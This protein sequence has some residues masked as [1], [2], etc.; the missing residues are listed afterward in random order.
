MCLWVDLSGFARMR[1]WAQT[2]RARVAGGPSSWAQAKRQSLDTRRM[3]RASLVSAKSRA[4]VSYLA[5]R[6]Y[7]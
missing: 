4:A 5:Q 3:K 7:D 6:P 1:F 2:T